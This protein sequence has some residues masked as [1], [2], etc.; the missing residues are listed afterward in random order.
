MASRLQPAIPA[1]EGLFSS[2]FS[3]AD[4]PFGFG[5]REA[6]FSPTSRP[7]RVFRTL[8]GTLGAECT[9]AAGQRHD[10]PSPCFPR[11]HLPGHSNG[12]KEPSISRR[13]IFAL[14]LF[15]EESLNLRKI[16]E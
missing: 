8:F 15:G 7:F 9:G 10:S 11:L 5:C 16:M 2:R 3:R 13:P 12:P 14:S 4:K 6:D 1:C